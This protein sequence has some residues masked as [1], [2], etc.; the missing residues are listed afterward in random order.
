MP[1]QCLGRAIGF[2]EGQ[3][4]ILHGLPSSRR[5]VRAPHQYPCRIQCNV[6]RGDA[7]ASGKQQFDPNR[8]V[9]AGH[10]AVESYQGGFARLGE[11]GQVVIGP[12]LVALVSACGDRAPDRVQFG[13]LIR[14]Q[15]SFVSPELVEGSPRLAAIDG[16]VTHDGGIGQQPEQSHLRHPAED[17]VIRLLTE[18]V[19]CDRMVDVPPPD[20]SQPE[21]NVY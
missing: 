1:G 19:S 7:T 21:A 9:A 8:G 5:L 6:K 12:Q 18:P 11:G 3:M 2:G 20:S 14:P 15:N 17:D 10:L 4:E 16:I 13:W